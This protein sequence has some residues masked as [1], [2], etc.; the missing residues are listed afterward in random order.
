[1]LAKVWSCA[2]TGLEGAL[3]EVEVD[4]S[5]GLPSF[6]IVGL[7]D[8]AVQEA[9][10]RVRSAIRNS[11]GMFPTQKVI[12][13]LAPADLRKA[14][15]AYDLPIAIGILIASGQVA[16]DTRHSLFIGEVALDGL[17][18]HTD[19]I[20]PMAC[21]AQAKGIK[22]IYVPAVDAPEAALLHDLSVIP[23]QSLNELAAHLNGDTYVETHA[24]M[25]VQPTANETAIDLADVKGQEHVKRALEISAAGA[26]NLLMFGP[27]GSG[28]TL[29]ARCLPAILPPLSQSEALE[30]TKI[31]SVKGLLPAEQPLIQQRPFR[32]PHHTISYAGLVGGGRT[33]QPGEI[34]LAHRGVL[35][36]DEMPEFGQRVL[37][38]LR[39]PME[40]KHVMISRAA[41]TLAF[42][43][44]FVL[45]GS[46]N[47]CPCGYHRSNGHNCTCS[48]AAISRYQKRL[49]GPLLDRIDMHI[50]V[51]RIEYEKLASQQ[52]GEP[53]A[54]IRQRVIAARQQQQQRFQAEAATNS[55]MAPAQIRMWCPLD[56]ACQN[57]IKTAMRQLNLSARAY[58][59]ILKLA[60]TIA[61]LGNSDTIQPI[62]LA[63]ALQYRSRHLEA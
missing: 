22:T 53:S 3:I 31:Y 59:R 6:T 8:A 4:I 1:M 49:S 57:L 2:V 27:P 10:E 11:G 29:L 20:L 14:G 26:H 17:L 12:V 21:V 28:K 48:P 18:R 32:A 45:V 43:A 61:D 60:R 47:P 5:P 38:V 36:L 62:H 40:D 25:V 42:P 37:Q 34:S 15:P 39:Q 55:G 30:V 51:P 44:N 23:I 19:G 63:E 50:E 52:A 16:A 7:P 33:P 41:G 58:H 24:P 9:R 13:N 35:F 46:L 56:S 54:T